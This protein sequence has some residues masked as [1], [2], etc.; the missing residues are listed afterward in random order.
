MSAFP[1]AFAVRFKNLERWD[2]SSF[3]RIQWHWDEAVM[4]PIGSVLR[5]RKEKVDRKTFK[6]A[7][8]Q[9]ITIHFDGS[10]DKRKLDSSREYTMDLFFAKPGDII[11]AKIDLKNGA[12][13]IVPDDWENVVVTSHFAVYE[14]ERSKLLPEY[15]HLIIQSQV[16]KSHLWRNK[17]GAEGRKEVKLDFFEKQLI[18]LPPLNTQRAIVARWQAAQDEV[19]AAHERAAQLEEE[20]KAR[21]LQDLGLPPMLRAKPLKCFAVTWRDLLRW[22]VN[23]NQQTQSGVDLTAACFPTVEL[24][25]IVELVQYGTSE[26][27]NSN[28]EG[29]AIVRMNNIINGVLNL[30]NLKHIVLPERER[31]KLILNRGDILFN[32]TNSKEL[33]GKCA[34]FDNQ[35]EY[36]F[37]SYLIRIRLDANK[38]L[39]E[40]VAFVINSRIGRQQI[41]ALSRQ[42]IGQANVNT[43]EL[44]SLLI[45]LPP[46]D[47]QR[48][49]MQRVAQGRDEAARE[50]KRAEQISHESMIETEALILGT[51]SLGS[52]TNFKH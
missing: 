29:T 33:V 32:R 23:Y 13:G 19:R 28:G 3:Q 34:V 22:G 1:E 7:D 25:S 15:L 50:R 41:D 11:A 10:M 43:E 2:V 37:A 26:K 14:P 42:I 44:R 31:A 48:E 47:V 24:G 27:A 20:L 4:Q 45:P 21:F 9:P 5:T 8:L 49:I 30:S 38:A 35:D 46:L 39:P 17:V 36:V 52:E 12:V 40:F 6:F 18:P 16:F 51:K